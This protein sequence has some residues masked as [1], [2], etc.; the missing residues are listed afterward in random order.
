MGWGRVPMMSWQVYR[1]ITNKNNIKKLLKDTESCTLWTVTWVC[2]LFAFPPSI[3]SRM[4][5]DWVNRRNFY[6]VMKQKKKNNKKK[7]DR[8][9]DKA[10]CIS[11]TWS[12]TIERVMS[13]KLT[14]ITKH[15]LLLTFAK[16]LGSPNR[17]N[18]GWIPGKS[19]GWENEQKGAGSSPG[20]T[21]NSVSGCGE[22]A[23]TSL[24]ARKSRR[25]KL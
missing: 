17:S 13:E 19:V 25:C 12:K 10:H 16:L 7:P 9:E 23:M 11:K 1:C 6:S 21:V 20:P 24:A 3:P 14:K 2:F 18:V 15:W 8:F 5:G 4:K 22:V